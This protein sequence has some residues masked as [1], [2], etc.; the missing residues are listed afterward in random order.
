[1][2]KKEELVEEY[3]KRFFTQHPDGMTV[4][5]YCN[6]WVPG[7]CFLD[8]FD[9]G[10]QAAIEMLRSDEGRKQLT[11]FE[12]DTLADWLESKKGEL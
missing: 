12:A 8:G 4:A 5:T 2:S 1:M 10:F 6:D 3:E 7:Q 11:Q 9:S